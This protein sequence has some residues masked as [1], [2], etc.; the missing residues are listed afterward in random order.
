MNPSLANVADAVESGRLGLG[1]LLALRSA[2]QAPFRLHPLGF[3]VCTLLTEGSRKL[4]LHYWPA[5]GRD[6]LSPECQ[7]HDH[8]FEF[9]SWVLAGT[10]ENIEYVVDPTGNEFAVYETSYS[11]NQSILTKTEAI[12]RLGEQ[13]RIAYS[14]KSCYS[15]S[16]GV[17]HETVLRGEAPAFTVLFTHDVSCAAPLVFGPMLG[18][19]SY[20]YDRAVVPEEEVDRMV[21]TLEAK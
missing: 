9:R 1:D 10:V 19:S 21:A 3:V 15:V 20:V 12:V 16:A 8:L 14:A 5:A 7:I 13:R 17:L 2:L 6:R 18:E 4:R 11:G